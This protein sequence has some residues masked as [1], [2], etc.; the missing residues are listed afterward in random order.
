MVSNRLQLLIHTRIQA[1]VPTISDLSLQNA[2]QF[3][4]D[5]MRHTRDTYHEPVSLLDVEWS[6][7]RELTFTIRALY[8]HNVSVHRL[9]YVSETGDTA[10]SNV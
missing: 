6:N 10:I 9:A 8:T 5:A 1:V 3:A 7:E 2:V 4:L